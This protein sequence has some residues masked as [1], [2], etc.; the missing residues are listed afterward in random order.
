MGYDG[1][2][3]PS[4]SPIGS[5]SLTGTRSFDTNKDVPAE[6]ERKP[7][8]ESADPAPANLAE[9]LIG[10]TDETVEVADLERY[11][12]ARRAESSRV[13]GGKGCR[14]RGAV[15]TVVRRRAEGKQAGGS[16]KVQSV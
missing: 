9:Y 4:V 8:I 6:K 7:P 16:G 13:R 10:G 5:S 12:A 11:R 15:E 3:N 1:N 2:R 14:C